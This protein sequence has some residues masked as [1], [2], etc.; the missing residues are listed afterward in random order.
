VLFHDASPPTASCSRDS[1]RS[2]RS[3]L[4]RRRVQGRRT[5]RRR[6]ASIDGTFYWVDV[7]HT[8]P[9]C[10]TSRTRTPAQ[11]G[12][13]SELARAGNLIVNGFVYGI[14]PAVPA[15][16]L[17]SAM[18]RVA[19]AGIPSATL[20]PI[21]KVLSE[22]GRDDGAIQV[23]IARK[24]RSAARHESLAQRAWSLVMQYTIASVTCRCARCGGSRASSPRHDPVRLGLPDA[25][26]RRPRNRL[27][28]VRRDRR[29]AAAL[30][31]FTRWSIRWKIS[32]VSSAS[33]QILAPE[34][35]SQREW[36]NDAYRRA[37]RSSSIPSRLLRWYLAA[38]PRAGRSPRYYSPACQD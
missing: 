22:M 34:S 20:S 8:R 38:H 33:G 5:T 9:R 7:K 23:R 32:A 29:S 4:S 28:R 11:S 35:A 27:P 26:Q 13:T 25:Y 16:G 2:A 10:S 15:T 31:V 6:G 1:R 3:Q 14:S 19:A 21:A 36:P 24:S 37:A 12:T 17:A 30:S 18:A